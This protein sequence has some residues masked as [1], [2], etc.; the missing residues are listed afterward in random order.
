MKYR[1]LV[2]FIILSSLSFAQSNVVTDFKENHETALSLYFYPSTLRMINIERN[3]E[4]DEMIREIKKARF[5][6]MD[7]GAVSKADLSKLEKDLTN[8]G[9][10]EVMFIKNKDTD[11]RVWGLDKRNPELVIIS[12]SDEELMLLEINGMLNIAKIPK[13]TQ[14]FNRSGFLEVLNLTGEKKKK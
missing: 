6:K 8:I 13:L 7:S 12:K 2:F 14:T 11:I 4:F 3:L 10:E 1:F 5:F 9:F